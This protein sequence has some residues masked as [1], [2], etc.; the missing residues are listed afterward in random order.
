MTAAHQPTHQPTERAELAFPMPGDA[1]PGAPPPLRGWPTPTTRTSDEP[2]ISTGGVPGTDSHSS[3]AGAHW[4]VLLTVSVAGFALAC[5]ALLGR[6][7]RRRAA[8]AM[9]D[10]G[11]S[12]GSV[13]R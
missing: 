7:L 2:A 9:T 1:V 10:Q 5:G 4:T 12:H 8:G 6:G 3:G 13:S 11:G